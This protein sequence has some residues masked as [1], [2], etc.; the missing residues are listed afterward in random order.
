MVSPLGHIVSRQ[1]EPTQ[2]QEAYILE[3]RNFVL[4]FDSLDV[5]SAKTHL[6]DRLQVFRRHIPVDEDAVDGLPLSPRVPF[7]RAQ[8]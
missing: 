1:L 3:Q 5:R 8:V 2:V 6:D 4:G 7:F